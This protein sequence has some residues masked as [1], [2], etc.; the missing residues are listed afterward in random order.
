VAGVPV[1]VVEVKDF[2]NG[3]LVERTLDY[4]AAHDDGS[5][6]YFGERVDDY[7]EGRVVGHSG[8]WLA[9]EGGARPAL[10]MPAEPG[11]GD[12]FE[13]EG[14]P[15][16]AEDRS[17]VLAV[18]LTVTTPAGTFSGCIRTRDVDPL[19][20]VVEFKLYCAGVG[21]VREQAPGSRL[22]LARYR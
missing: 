22:E 20:G 12:A 15:G 18:S 9:G 2:E 11:V 10:F 17:T 4:Y 19:D 8:Q 3:K 14:A 1:A 16:I 5:V 21:L 6:W 13:Q 7:E